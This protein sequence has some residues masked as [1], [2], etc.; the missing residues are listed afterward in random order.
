MASGEARSSTVSLLVDLDTYDAER[1]EEITLASAGLRERH[2][3]EEPRV[4]AGAPALSDGHAD[5]PAEIAIRR[6]MSECYLQTNRRR[7]HPD[8][9]SCAGMAQVATRSGAPPRGSA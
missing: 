1:M 7:R 3:D 4:A 5:C 9:R 6:V 2:Q 8:R